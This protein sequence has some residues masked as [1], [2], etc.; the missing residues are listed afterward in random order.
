VSKL[1]GPR[2]PAPPLFD[3]TCLDGDIIIEGLEPRRGK[4]TITIPGVR[5][6]RAQVF[7]VVKF[8]AELWPDQVTRIVSDVHRAL[9]GEPPLQA[10]RA[11]AQHVDQPEEAGE[12]HQAADLDE[13]GVRG[14]HPQQQTE[15][16]ED[17]RPD[18]D[19]HGPDSTPE[20]SK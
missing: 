10:Q 7:S 17:E 4:G 9:A 15:H 12:E 3:L 5:L 2:P 13:L 8:S 16:G 19:Q 11:P 18:S 20:V 1:R 14:Q 6:T